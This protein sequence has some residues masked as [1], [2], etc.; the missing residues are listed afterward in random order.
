MLL[1]GRAAEYLVLGKD[2][3]TT[4]ASN[5]LERAAEIVDKM[6]CELGMSEL[7]LMTYRRRESTFLASRG[8]GSLECSPEMA[9]KIDAEKSRIINDEWKSVLDLMKE[10][11]DL[12]KAVAAGLLSQETLDEGDL[13]KILGPAAV[14][15]A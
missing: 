6:V 15:K 5:D 9:A 1:G 3:I 2:K 7:G 4:G 12:L 14:L 11:M 13:L 8:G 10:K